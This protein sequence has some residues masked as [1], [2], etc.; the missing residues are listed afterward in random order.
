MNIKHLTLVILITVAAIAVVGC[1]GAVI[2][3]AS[4]GSE[5]STATRLAV[6][7]MK[8]EGTSQAKER[9]TLWEA[10]QSMSS[11]DT[12]AQ[13]ELDA[14][15][16]QIQRTLT[17]EQVQAIEAMDLTTQSVS[18]VAQPAGVTGTNSASSTPSASAS[19]GASSAQLSSGA[20]SGAAGVPP[21]GGMPMNSSNPLAD[22]TGGTSAQVTP[23][24]TKASASQ[25]TAQV[26]P[27]VLVALIQLLQT[28][29]QL[30]G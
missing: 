11:S 6:G 10:Y 22:V 28:R 24:A 26:N 18:E 17:A 29:S 14:L 30:A 4:A 16:S 5:L 8:L 2:T 27:Q 13:V 19:G 9:L 25:S 20:P 23:S 3:T 1:S 15:V 12:T 21:S 7:T